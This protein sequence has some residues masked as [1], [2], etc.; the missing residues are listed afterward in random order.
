MLQ[1]TGSVFDFFYLVVLGVFFYFGLYVTNK[2]IRF[3]YFFPQKG[4]EFIPDQG[5][6]LVTLYPGLVLLPLIKNAVF[7]EAHSKKYAFV[8]LDLGGF[9]IIF[10]LLT[11]VVVLHV[12][13]ALVH[14][15]HPMF[16]RLMKII[17]RTC[18]TLVS[19][20][21]NTGLYKLSKKYI[22]GDWFLSKKG[23][24]AQNG[25]LKLFTLDKKHNDS[26]SKAD[27]GDKVGE[28]L[29]NVF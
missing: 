21:F 5:S 19:S 18:W 29:F 22:G 13:I 11:K 12:Q 25:A 4:L 15:G 2:H 28:V 17:I 24:W 10:A 9:K 3:S 27:S 23:L 16:E 1:I 14:I 26:K 8:A 7:Q 6:Q 20:L